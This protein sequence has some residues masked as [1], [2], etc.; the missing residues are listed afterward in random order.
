[1]K[2]RPWLL[3]GGAA[4]GEPTDRG[5]PTPTLYPWLMPLM[6]CCGGGFHRNRMVVEFTASACT[7]CGG[8]VGTVPRRPAQGGKRSQMSWHPLVTGDHGPQ[9]SEEPG[10]QGLLV[11]LQGRALPTARLRRATPHSTGAG[12]DWTKGQQANV[13]ISFSAAQ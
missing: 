9:G 2:M 6:N 8:A 3:H 13:L 11:T 4:P 1:M 12:L 10:R 7:F 5:A